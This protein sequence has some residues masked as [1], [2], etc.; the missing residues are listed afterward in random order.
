MPPPLSAPE[1]SQSQS[2]NLLY[3]RHG[4]ITE[5]APCT[6]ETH[7]CAS[8]HKRSQ[9]CCTL[10]KNHRRLS[11]ANR[12]GR[13]ALLTDSMWAMISFQKGWPG[14]EAITL[15]T[16]SRCSRYSLCSTRSAPASHAS[17]GRKHCTSRSRY[18]PPN[19]CSRNGRSASPGEDH[20]LSL[21]TLY[22]RF[23]ITAHMLS[24]EGAAQSSR[25]QKGVK[26]RDVRSGS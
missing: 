17:L 14:T 25:M 9:F 11:E 4:T 24:M 23:Y 8:I 5:A 19:A 20:Q 13:R 7:L 18:M 10:I 21:S 6:S 15:F 26:I 3:A 1:R 2:I 16:M 22:I 12:C